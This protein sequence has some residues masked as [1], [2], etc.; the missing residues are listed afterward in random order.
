[1]T[2]PSK[3]L[4]LSTRIAAATALVACG[5]AV[6]QALGGPPP[7]SL[8]KAAQAEGQIMIYS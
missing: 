7:A 1:M 5:P 3:R 2:N 4:L 8:V 6:A